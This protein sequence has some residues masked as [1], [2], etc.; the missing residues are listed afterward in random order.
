MVEKTVLQLE[1]LA[2]KMDTVLNRTLGSSGGIVGVCM[3][4]SKMDIWLLER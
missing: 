2:F 3:K 1:I 4:K